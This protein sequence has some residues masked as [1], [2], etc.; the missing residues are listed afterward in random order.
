MRIPFALALL[1]TVPS[2]SLAQTK[3]VEDAVRTKLGALKFLYACE[4][5]AGGFYPTLPPK[6]DAPPKPSLRATSAAVRAIKYMG[7]KVP[8]AGKHAAFVLQCF[9]PVTGGFA[10]SPGGKPDVTITAIGVMAAVEFDIPKEKFRKAMDYLKEH[11]KTFEEV[12]IGAAA[13][14]AWGVKDCPFKLDGWFEIVKPYSRKTE[15]IAPRGMGSLAA[16]Y[17]RL[18]HPL[19]DP[20]G[21]RR[22]LIEGQQPDGGWSVLGAKGSDMATTYRV[23]RAFHMMKEK[24]RDVAKLRTFVA[25]CRNADGG[26]GTTPG[27]KSSVG[28]VYYAAIIT[29]W[30]DQAEKK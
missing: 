18:G 3:E 8:N 20:A 27:G 10:D 25:K 23:M 6:T 11:A 1:L 22:T 4:D 19:F 29:K 16:F 9:D 17:L 12:R 15:S 28:G 5:P 13:V 24:P 7:G 2:A 21:V 30:L 14:E 26:F